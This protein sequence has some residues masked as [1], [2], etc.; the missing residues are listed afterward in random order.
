MS[1][2]NRVTPGVPTGGQF[3]ATQRGEADVDLS[4]TTQA[5]D[6]YE[7]RDGCCSGC[8]GQM[9]VD[10]T[11]VSNHIDDNGDIDFDVD[12]EHVA[13]M[14]SDVEQIGGGNLNLSVAGL[15]NSDVPDDVYDA[16]RDC[17]DEGMVGWNAS[18]EASARLGHIDSDTA[19]YQRDRNDIAKAL[20]MPTPYPAQAA[21]DAAS[22]ED[23]AALPGDAS[24]EA[25]TAHQR[26]AADSFERSDTD[27][28]LSQHVSGLSAQKA[29]LQAYIDDDGGRARYTALADTDGNLV[30]AKW[31]NTQYGGAYAK[32]SDPDDPSS[33][34]DGF[35]NT[36]KAADPEKQRK[37]LADRGYKEVYVMAPAYADFGGGSGTGMSGMTSVRAVSIRTDG[38]FS[39][40]VE[41]LPDEMRYF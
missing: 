17:L 1:N 37:Y 19:E 10:P 18:N 24:R 30:A 21:E 13:L 35:V 36:S 7:V 4:P 2:P 40:D 8:G 6:P 16:V 27:G 20:G 34:F 14:E 9:V 28:F 15:V 38:G 29:S 32:L 5:S 12:M 31:I 11:G 23:T 33:A 22:A 25:A 3:A 41:I 26:E 39:R